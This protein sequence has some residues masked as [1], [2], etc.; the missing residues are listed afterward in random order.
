M[1]ISEDNKKVVT[2]GWIQL[3]IA[4]VVV[5]GG[6]AATAAGVMNYIYSVERR[7]AIVEGKQDAFDKYGSITARAAATA[8]EVIASKQTSDM[9]SLN[10]QLQVLQKSVDEIKADV[11]EHLKLSVNS[12]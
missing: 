5:L 6:M 7:L 9:S 1:T 12:K 2:M 10:M 3:G 11:K 8:T 4:I